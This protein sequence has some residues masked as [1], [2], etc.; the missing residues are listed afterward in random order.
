MPRAI[1]VNM[2][3]LRLTSEAQPRS[4]NGQPPHRTTGVASSEFDP[5]DRAHRENS[6]QRAGPG[7]MSD[8]PSS[9]HGNRERDA[10]PE[11]ARHGNEFGIFFFFDDGGA[12]LKS[13]AA[14]RAG[15]RFGA[16]DFRM[17]RAGVFDARRG[18]GGNVGL[19]G[20]AA[21]GA[22]AGMV[23]ANFGVHRADV[24]WARRFAPARAAIADLRLRARR[25]RA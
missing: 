1:S 11:S 13:H 12:R 4:K 15:A 5:A 22:G 2:F 19:E 21:F 20:H 24:N 6:L 18:R 3:R 23:L 14:N 10:D 9:K 25:A 16:H 8:M 7:S 17:H